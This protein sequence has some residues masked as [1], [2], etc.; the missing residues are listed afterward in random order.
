MLLL[1]ILAA[2]ATAC[3]ASVHDGDT[4]TLCNHERVR[5]VGIDAPEV[6]GSPRC[7]AAQRRRLAGSKN[8]AWC[9]YAKGTRSRDALRAYLK[10][11]TVRIERR[12]HDKYGRTLA[13]LSVNGHDAGRYLVG[14]G[15]ARTWR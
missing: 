7:K 14:M 9:D 1:S 8:P 11:G 12:G 2:S 10:T 15:L 13:R 5:L 6:K 3:I 4:V